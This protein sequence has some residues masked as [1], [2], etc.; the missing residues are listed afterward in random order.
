MLKL[1]QMRFWNVRGRIGG[2]EE[3]QD[4]STGHVPSPESA[5]RAALARTAAS[6]GY[7]AKAGLLVLSKAAEHDP[8]HRCRVKIAR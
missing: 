7:V 6:K 8:E 5:Q 4:L 1:K 2:K 3:R